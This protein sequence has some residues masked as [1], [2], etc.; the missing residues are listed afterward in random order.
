[1]TSIDYILLGVIRP[2]SLT[3]GIDLE[4]DWRGQVYPM[5]VSSSYKP[6]VAEKLR[7]QRTAKWGDSN[8]HCC[9]YYCGSGD[10]CWTDWNNER[11]LL[12]GKGVRD[13]EEVAQ[14][15]CC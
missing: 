11:M 13:W 12:I 7:S 4:A 1:M 14:L 5:Y 10:C 6:A 3:N 8:V 2:V 15:G 9:A